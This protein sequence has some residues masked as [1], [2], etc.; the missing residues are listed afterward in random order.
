MNEGLAIELWMENPIGPKIGLHAS[1]RSKGLPTGVALYFRKKLY[2]FLSTAG[3]E[4]IEIAASQNFL[5]GTL[6]RRLLGGVQS[7]EGRRFSAY[8]ARL[9]DVSSHSF[10]NE[11]KI[12]DLDHFSACLGDYFSDP[13]HLPFVD[14]GRPVSLAQLETNVSKI[15]GTSILNDP[16]SSEPIAIRLSDS[17]IFLYKEEGGYRPLFWKE[18]HQRHPDWVRVDVPLGKPETTSTP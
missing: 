12:R 11:Y 16:I 13:V 5:V 7:E 8:M 2:H 1:Q 4:N 10:S 3:F 6:Y 17:L 15:N 14:L 18:I 9:Y